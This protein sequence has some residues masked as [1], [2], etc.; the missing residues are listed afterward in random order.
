MYQY[1]EEARENISEYFQSVECGYNADYL[2]ERI[3]KNLDS[4]EKEYSTLEDRAQ[5]QKREL[6]KYR[7]KYGE[8]V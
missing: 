1:I 6:N 3:S 7:A 2:V 5:R 8:I 4:I